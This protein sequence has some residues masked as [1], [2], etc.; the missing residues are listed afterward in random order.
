MCIKCL[1]KVVCVRNTWTNRWIFVACMDLER[2]CVRVDRD[3]LWKVLRIYN[4]G[5]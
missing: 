2:A 5:D 1:L 4:V 3:A